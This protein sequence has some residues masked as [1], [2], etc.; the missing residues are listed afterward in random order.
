MCS[1]PTMRSNSW[2][3]CMTRC[4]KIPFHTGRRSS[5]RIIVF[6]SRTWAF[7][8]AKKKCWNI[9]LFPWKKARVTLLSGIPAPENPPLP[10]SYPVFTRWIPAASPSVENPLKATAKQRFVMPL[11][12]C[13]K[14]VSSSIKAFMRMFFSEN[15]KLLK[16]KCFM[17]WNLQAARKSFPASPKGSTPSSAQR[18]ST[19]PVGKSRESL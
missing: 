13:F 18:V 2:R 8:M 14:I 4:R 16:M 7:P 17:L 12:L 10:S 6:P 3:L 9:F 1:M 19:S 15:R 11:P 5:S